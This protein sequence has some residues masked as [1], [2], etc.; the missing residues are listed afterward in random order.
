MSIGMS[1]QR[2]MERQIDRPNRE[3][4]WLSNR[5]VSAAALCALGSYAAL[6]AVAALGMLSG[7]FSAH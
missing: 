2:R 5:L 7:F 1:A 3:E 4:D 6:F